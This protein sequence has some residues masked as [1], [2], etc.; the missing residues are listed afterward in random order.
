[1][2]ILSVS[3]PPRPLFV[4]ITLLVEVTLL[5]GRMLPTGTGDPFKSA[6]ET[7]GLEPSQSTFRSVP[8][9]TCID[10]F[11]YDVIQP[12]PLTFVTVKVV[13]ICASTDAFW[14][15]PLIVAV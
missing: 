3:L 2:D 9:A 11:V 10:L 1:M 5:I 12:P 7:A 13:W 14:P 6:E 8:G 4:R 15:P